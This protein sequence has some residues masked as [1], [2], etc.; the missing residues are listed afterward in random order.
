M[1]Q[2]TEN[3]NRDGTT[4]GA[5]SGTGTVLSND[6]AV[7]EPETRDSSAGGA[8]DSDMQGQEQAPTVRARH[9]PAAAASTPTRA[10][11]LAESWKV[12]VCA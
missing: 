7:A 1:E 4:G 11:L 9:A 12:A 2:N 8:V 5:A 10:A 6:S 3:Q